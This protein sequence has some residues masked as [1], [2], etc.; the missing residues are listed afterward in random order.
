MEGN[1]EER[2]ERVGEVM[3]KGKSEKNW[4]EKENLSGNHVHYVNSVSFGEEESEY[5]LEERKLR[6]RRMRESWEA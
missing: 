1:T 6:E 2:R 3:R 4:V 5:G